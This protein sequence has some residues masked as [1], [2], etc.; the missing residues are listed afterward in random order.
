MEHILPRTDHKESNESRWARGI[1]GSALL[2]AGL[3]MR[4][5]FGALLSVAGADLITKGITGHHLYEAAGI[6]TL[7]RTGRRASV[8]HQLG[9]QVQHSVL[10]SLPAEE[11]YQFLHNLENLPRFL[12]HVQSLERT[13][14]NRA[15]W[16]MRGPAGMPLEWDSEIINDVANEQIGWRSV[17]SPEVEMAGA[18]RLDSAPQGRGTTVRLSLQYVPVGGA[19]G[20]LIAKLFGRD[21]E[22]EIKSDMRRLKQLLE[23]GE[24]ATT[25][26]QPAGGARGAAAFQQRRAHPEMETP[27][28]YMTQV[29]DVTQIPEAARSASASSSSQ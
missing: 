28:P 12:T 17:D 15:H 6:T 8:P 21:P 29:P 4:S 7:T 1:G 27:P 5:R 13:G 18:V 19:F 2:I 22:R 10:V 16:V 24:I 23:A 3:K 9:V 26:G 11:I 20:A 14:D 25:R